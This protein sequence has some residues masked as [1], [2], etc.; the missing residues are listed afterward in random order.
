MQAAEP[1]ALK[2]WQQSAQQRSANRARLETQ[3]TSEEP[4]ENDAENGAS[5][6]SS[7]K[8]LMAAF[9]LDASVAKQRN[10]KSQLEAM[11][12]RCVLALELDVIAHKSSTMMI[13]LACTNMMCDV[14]TVTRPI[15]HEAFWCRRRAV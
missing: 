10:A 3:S 11:G 13:F 14:L 15:P 9:Y 1:D 6:T 7:S 4:V 12:F 5:L 2:V 8:P